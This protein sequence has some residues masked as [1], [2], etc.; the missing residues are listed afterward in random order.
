MAHRDGCS[1]SDV[2]L[3]F[4]LG[5]IA[6]AAVM[7]LYAPLS[8][9]ETRERIG[10]GVRDA[11]ERGRARTRALVERGRAARDQVVERGAELGRRVSRRAVDEDATSRDTEGGPEPS[12]ES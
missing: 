8:G 4:V 11:A 7:V 5:G 2:L 1:G 3:A 12:R 6:G 9:P 10:R